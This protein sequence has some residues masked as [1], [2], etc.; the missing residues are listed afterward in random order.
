MTQNFRSRC[1]RETGHKAH[2][3]SQRDCCYMWDRTCD[4]SKKMQLRTMW[5]NEDNLGTVLHPQHAF[6]AVCKALNV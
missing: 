6:Y 3:G 1:Q 5:P 4:I 2:A